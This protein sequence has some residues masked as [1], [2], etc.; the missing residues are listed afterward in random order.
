LLRQGQALLRLSVARFD[1]MNALRLLP[2]A[3]DPRAR[4]DQLTERMQNLFGSSFVVLPRFSLGTTAAPEI[5]SALAAS[6]AV[7]GNDSLA[8]HT[9]FTRAA[10]VRDSLGRFATC[11]RSSEVLGAAARLNLS[12][13]QL[14]FVSGER[15]V[16]L[17]P[18]AGQSV[19]PGKL[20]LVIHTVG[21]FTPSQVLT[22]LVIDEWTEVVPNDRETTA[23]TFQFDV[24]DSCAPQCVLVAV[25]P[26]RGQ[27]WTVDSL[28]Q[29]LVET[30]D[31]AKLRAVDTGSLGAAAQYL[32]GL[33][34]AFN[35]Q[36]HAVST[37][38]APLTA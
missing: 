13:A 31:L 32:P 2:V 37:D 28:R 38:F 33:Y 22:G 5:K 20:S 23:L 29:L 35:T 21:T 4:R 15:W 34:L 24:P 9:W 8:A 14:P 3:A 36:D 12:V 25:P 6:L 19:T 27:D 11:L 7:Q 10:R 16:A 30:L 18:L 17:A 1:R 26:V